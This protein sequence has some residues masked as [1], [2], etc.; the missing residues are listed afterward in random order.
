MGYCTVTHMLYMCIV[1]YTL[2][3]VRVDNYTHVYTCR[4]DYIK[5]SQ[6]LTSYAAVFYQ[7]Q[8]LKMGLH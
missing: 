4:Q 6:K 3:I 7:L 2:S 1:V 8:R 5:L